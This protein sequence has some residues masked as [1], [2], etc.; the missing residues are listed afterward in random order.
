MSYWW[1]W[2]TTTFDINSSYHLHS[3]YITFQFIL[4]EAECSSP[5]WLCT[6]SWGLLWLTAA[7]QQYAAWH[8]LVWSGFLSG[9]LPLSW[10]ERVSSVCSRPEEGNRNT[11][12][13]RLCLLLGAKPRQTQARTLDLCE[14]QMRM[15]K[16]PWFS[17]KPL[18]LG[19]FISQDYW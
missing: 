3:C 19:K 9:P 15:S 1:L 10:E 17:L 8:V 2:E 7:Q 6:Q 4:A 11:R 14:P 5:S 13:T 18:S 16:N 12:G